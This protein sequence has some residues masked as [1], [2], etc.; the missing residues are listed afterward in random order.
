MVHKVIKRL[1]RAYVIVEKE[2][3]DPK[4]F[5]VEG[6]PDRRRTKKMARLMSGMVS[7]VAFVVDSTSALYKGGER[8]L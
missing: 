6:K 5:I 7:D 2:N 3:E 8:R 1:N 4:L